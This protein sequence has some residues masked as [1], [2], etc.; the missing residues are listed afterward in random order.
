LTDPLDLVEAFAKT[1]EALLMAANEVRPNLRETPFV[2]HWDLMDLLAHLV[3]WDYTNVEAI[4]QLRVG[5]TPSFYAQYDAGWASYNQQLIDRYGG[6]DWNEVRGAL[7]TSQEAIVA[8]LRLLAPE[9]LTREL[10]NPGR[11]SRPVTIVGI[12]RAAISD[13]EEHWDRYGR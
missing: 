3:G 8:M 9:E 13:E 4:E 10:A 7:L 5:K 1:R 12:L 11:P 2:G 6:D